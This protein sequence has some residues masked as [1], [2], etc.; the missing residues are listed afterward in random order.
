MKRANEIL[1]T[2]KSKPYFKSIQKHSCY[3]RLLEFLPP[4][5]QKAIAFFYIKNNTLFG[6]LSHPGFKNELNY[7]KDLLK[8]LLKQISTIELEC[9]ELFDCVENIV[10]FTSKHHTPAPLIA[11]TS[12][13]KYRELAKGEFEILTEDEEL[14]SIF[15]K[16]KE[17]IIVNVEDLQ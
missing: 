3:N 7:N 8:E 10:F 4:R 15:R 14:A 12:I 17:D 2:V 1:K 6:A 13:P 5:F 11:S 9:K 16:I